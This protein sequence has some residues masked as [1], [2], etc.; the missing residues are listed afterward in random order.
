[1]HLNRFKKI[2]DLIVSFIILVISL[3]DS[4]GKK[5]W[6]EEKLRK[7]MDELRL[8]LVLIQALNKVGSVVELENNA[9]SGGILRDSNGCFLFVFAAR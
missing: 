3:F 2:F 9:A 1:M 5:K 7:P 8:K 6:E 4:M